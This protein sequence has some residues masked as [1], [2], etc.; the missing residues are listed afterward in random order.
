MDNLRM[1]DV[2]RCDYEIYT[3]VTVDMVVPLSR[4]Q[5]TSNYTLL[6]Q[7]V[8]ARRAIYH[9]NSQAGTANMESTTNTENTTAVTTVS[10]ITNKTVVFQG[11]H[12]DLTAD[13][14]AASR[15][16]DYWLTTLAPLGQQPLAPA[17]YKFYRDVV[18]DYK[19]DNTGKTDASEAINAAIQD[20]NRCG[21]TCSS[22]FTMGAIVY[23]PPGTYKICSPV[24]QLYYTQFIG[25]AI[26][27]PTIKGCSSFKGIA[28]FDT[29]P[30]IPGG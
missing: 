26:D 13:T 25:D 9:N 17:G 2:H 21:K 14:N 20:G 24:I 7:T 4:A 27:V 19:A 5:Y 16:V 1:G 6:N 12:V 10:T 28:L 30:Y 29:D 8:P 15:S 22:T 18:K 11:L 23:F 3:N